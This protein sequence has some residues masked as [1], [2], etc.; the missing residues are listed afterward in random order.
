MHKTL[1][2]EDIE[3]IADVLGIEAK[4]E[5]DHWTLLLDSLEHQRHLRVEI[6]PDISIGK[7]TGSLVSVYTHN[8]HLQLH[9]VSGYVVS[10]LL[11]EVTFIAEREGWVS[12]LTVEREAA[13]SLY[14]NVDNSVLSGDFT[15]LGPEVML[16]GIA[17]CLTD[18]MSDLLDDEDE[19]SC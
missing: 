1:V 7:D 8:S 3:R 13:C 17:L 4:F 18:E 10:T 9:F 16:S 2:T 5:A 12:G 11:G 19:N 6:Y 15:R 14:A